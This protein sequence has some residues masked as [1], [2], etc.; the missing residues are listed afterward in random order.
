MKIVSIYPASGAQSF[1]FGG[2]LVIIQRLSLDISLINVLLHFANEDKNTN[3]KLTLPTNFL[4]LRF[5][6]LLKLIN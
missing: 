3:T 1:F 6:M 4:F 5:L 2:D